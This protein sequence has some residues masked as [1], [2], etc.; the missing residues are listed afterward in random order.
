MSSGLDAPF[1][2]FDKLSISPGGMRGAGKDAGVPPLRTATLLLLEVWVRFKVRLDS[3]A[4]LRVATGLGTV[5]LA[6]SG[7]SVH[8]KMRAIDKKSKER[9]RSSK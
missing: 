5:P 9:E 6:V 7:L 1:V 4:R 2:F 3:L 8:Q